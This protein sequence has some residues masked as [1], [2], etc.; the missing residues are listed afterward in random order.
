MKDITTLIAIVFLSAFVISSDSER[1]FKK[2]YALE[3]TW[4]MT[5]RRGAMCE[6]W[7]KMD[8]YL[9]QNKGYMIRGSDTIINERVTLT[10]TATD[11]FYTSTV[12]AQN[13][14]QPIA[15]KMT[16]NEHD[17]FVFE[18]PLHDFPRR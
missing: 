6:E 7:K 1:T 15:F 10:R 13:N 11:I 16:K 5:T 14:R 3:G 12:E 18:N 8:K 4:K 2:L 9:L 17:M